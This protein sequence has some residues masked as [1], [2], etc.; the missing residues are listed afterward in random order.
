MA[1]RSRPKLAEACIAQALAIIDAQGVEGLSLREVARRLGVSHQ[2]PYKHFASRDHL[3]A[4]VVTRAF[5]QFADTLAARPRHADPAED[6]AGLCRAYLAF[7]RGQALLFRLL[8]AT[9]VPQAAR[10]EELRAQGKR[11]FGL[12]AE[13]MLRLRPDQP[14]PVTMLDA[15]FVWST[16]HGLAGVMQTGAVGT[17]PGTEHADN[18]AAEPHVLAR[19]IAAVGTRFS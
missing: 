9:Q 15:V 6:L 16:V 5:T 2:A 14:A 8:F 13:V 3:L 12:L 10:D 11:A 4:A 1:A 18:D 7:A 17:L 19:V